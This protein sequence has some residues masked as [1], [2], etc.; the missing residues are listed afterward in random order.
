[1]PP[2]PC[3]VTHNL[4]LSGMVCAE[5]AEIIA[6]GLAG[7]DGVGRVTTDWIRSRVTVT[8]DPRRV[9]I[10]ALEKL[11]TEIGFPPAPGFFQ[12]RKRDWIR[13]VDQNTVDGFAHRGACCNRPPR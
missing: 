7:L 2:E 10:D 12:R 9:R 5:C 13:F 6:E 11:L 3:E 8:Y 4:Q 1:M